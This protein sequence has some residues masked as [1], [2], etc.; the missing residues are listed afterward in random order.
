MREQGLA[1]ASVVRGVDS[2]TPESGQPARRFAPVAAPARAPRF[3]RV[4]SRA[5][6][7]RE[8]GWGHPA[9]VLV[10][11]AT[12]LLRLRL[13]SSTDDPCVESLAPFEVD[14]AALDEEAR[15]K[16]QPLVEE[17]QALGFHSPI[18]HLI[19][20]DLHHTDTCLVTLAHESG[21]AWARVHLRLWTFP[22]PHKQALFAECVTPFANGT[23]LWSLSSKPDLAAPRSCQVVR[24]TGASPSELWSLHQAALE[25]A[26]RRPIAAV[27]TADLVRQSLERHH[28]AVRAFHVGRGVFVPA[29]AKDRAEVTRCAASRKASKAIGSRHP[30]VVAEMERLSSQP[31]AGKHGLLLLVVSAALFLGAFSTGNAPLSPRYL[32]ILVPVLLFHEAG[33]WL[34][35][36][37][38]GYRNLKMFFIPFF[39]AAVSG[40]H[41]NVPG[42]KKAVV[43][44]MGPLPGIVL[45]AVLGTLGL[46]LAKPLLVQIALVALI[47]NAINLLPILP[48]DGGWVV[49]AILASRSILFEVVFRGLAVAALLAAGFLANDVALK[50]LGFVMLVSL[51]MSVKVARI[52][53]ELRRAELPPASP[54][55]D[56]IPPAT[57]AAIADRVAAAFTQR[58]NTPQLAQLSLTVFEALNARPPRLL[59]SLSLAAVQ[60]F[61]LLGAAVFTIAMAVGQGGM[62]LAVFNG[63]TGAG[64]L[65]QTEL[66]PDRF[67]EWRASESESL[68]EA[69]HNVVVAS[70]G[71]AAEAERAAE[72]VKRKATAHAAGATFGQSLM[73][74]LPAS[75]DAARQQWLAALR[76]SASDVFVATKATPANVQISCE[77][78]SETAAQAIESEA[79]DYFLAPGMRLV[80]PWIDRDTRTEDERAMHAD[81]EPKD[82]A[83]SATGFLVRT[84]QTVN[85]PYLRFASSFAG[86]PAMVR[87]LRAKGCAGFRYQLSAGGEALEESD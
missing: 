7:L 81:A 52:A 73:L 32:A 67:A 35:M 18:H 2:L 71:S 61:G 64:A 78:S 38:F 84:G 77:A 72:D 74:A 13:P 1:T 40:R 50:V 3:Y 37:A 44:L 70:F 76:A 5:V 53:G 80:P 63:L 54:V 39:G 41:Y 27:G 34:A 24:K 31:P 51:P 11:A 33:H 62:G 69:P 10:G 55:D 6:T 21:R 60:L 68:L 36:R 75:D 43:S 57:S 66:D 29:S 28:A 86:P 79:T 4:D 26:G 48:L 46:L 22:A 58:V 25:K 56:S 83:L 12:K 65:P 20:D 14:G 47:L 82:H 9:A 15:G 42:W 16:L 23:F 8:Y 19:E 85:L 17:L 45:G 49:Q 87:W 59:A 30:R